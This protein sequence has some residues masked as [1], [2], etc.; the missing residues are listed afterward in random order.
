MILVQID[1]RAARVAAR[2]IELPSTRTLAP[3][4]LAGAI[5]GLLP[6]GTRRMSLLIPAGWCYV[7]RIT[8]PAR[9]PTAAMLA[10]ALEEFLPI[11]VERLTCDFVRG[12][13][14]A[15]WG[16][17][18][19]SARL[20][21]L[22]DALAQVGVAVESIRPA[23]PL[24]DR[25]VAWVDDEH[26]VLVHGQRGLVE[27]LRV[28]RAA[29]DADGW[30]ERVFRE[31]KS[32]EPLQ[33]GGP[34]A[35]ECDLG[36]GVTRIDAAGALCPI[37]LARGQ[38]RPVDAAQRKWQALRT[39]AAASL[40][41]A[42]ILLGAVWIAGARVSGELERIA[43]WERAVYAEVFPGERIPSGVA[44][45]LASERRRL[46]LLSGATDDGAPVGPDALE[47]LRTLIA[48]LPTDVL[49]NVQE[50]RIERDAV[51]LR[52]LARDHAAAER[53]AQS[54]RALDGM[55]PT[56]PRTDRQKDG[57]V[58]FFV[59]ATRAKPEGKP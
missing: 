57:S 27:E 26:L 58:Q 16:V 30:S 7:Q 14:G 8:L 55:E 54:L 40:V 2:R 44:L 6:A 47:I 42:V 18:I 10:F 9:R 52:G 43:A 48:A 32:P 4:A 11:E 50:L 33:V 20:R 1:D 38:L 15:W 46:E 41:A 51:I 24:A 3:V 53:L 59:T 28:I 19:E 56:A 5:V 49:I 22:L 35:L 13:G 39:L 29:P 12:A 34:G 45:R 31:L 21:P 17:A 37:E 23:V 36:P 25:R